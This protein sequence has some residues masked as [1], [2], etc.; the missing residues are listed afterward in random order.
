MSRNTCTPPIVGIPSALSM[1]TKF[2][3]HRSLRQPRR[4]PPQAMS[5]PYSMFR[6]RFVDLSSTIRRH[7][8]TSLT[9]RRH[10]VNS[11]RRLKVAC[12][13]LGGFWSTC[14]PISENRTKCSGMG[15]R[16][17]VWSRG[18]GRKSV[19]LVLVSRPRGLKLTVGRSPAGMARRDG[20][21]HGPRGPSRPQFMRSLRI[22]CWGFSSHSGSL[23]HTRT[24]MKMASAT[25]DDQFQAVLTTNVE[26]KFESTGC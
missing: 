16:H 7:A 1:C 24:W 15:L 26:C 22:P 11:S 9:F 3:E 2:R 25:N 13:A 14:M 17:G 21:R 20:A 12:F 19:P 4:F 23:Q 10:F 18:F 8:V 5:Q 6:R